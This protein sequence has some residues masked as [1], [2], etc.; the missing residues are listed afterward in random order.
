MGMRARIFCIGNFTKDIAKYLE[1]PEE[2]YQDVNEGT[3]VYSTLC[4]CNTQAA[5]VELARVLGIV[6]WNFNEHFITP[7]KINPTKW[8][9][10]TLPKDIVNGGND[11]PGENAVFILRKLLA[12]GFTCI[13]MPEG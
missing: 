5:S 13:Y 7:A 4:R 1:Y 3:L 12:H 6:P 9:S 11:I 8:E 2:F 10:S